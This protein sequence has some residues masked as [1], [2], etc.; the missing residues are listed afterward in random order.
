MKDFDSSLVRLEQPAQ[1]SFIRSEDGLAVCYLL[2]KH[3]FHT[4]V[5]FTITMSNTVATSHTSMEG[6]YG[7][8]IVSCVIVVVVVVDVGTGKF[9]MQIHTLL[10]LLAVHSAGTHVGVEL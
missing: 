2:S 10:I 6:F 9:A 3:P 4:I 7:C 8:M 5:F 1:L